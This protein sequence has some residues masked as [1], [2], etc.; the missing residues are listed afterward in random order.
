MKLAI[1]VGVMIAGISAAQAQDGFGSLRSQYDLHSYG[2]Q[3][4][5]YWNPPAPS[6]Y[7][8]APDS[9]GLVR[10][11]RMPPQTGLGGYPTNLPQTWRSE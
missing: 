6:G 4:D 2:A 3:N 7:Y 5:S 10:Q 8:N 9:M 1:S 11:Y